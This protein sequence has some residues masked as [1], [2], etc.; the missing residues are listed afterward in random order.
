MVVDVHVET[1]VTAVS[2]L[3]FY[4]SAVVVAAMADSVSETA[5]AEMVADAISS[6]LSFFF[7]AAVAATASARLN[8]FRHRVCRPPGLQA[9]TVCLLTG[10]GISCKKPEIR[11]IPFSGFSI[12]L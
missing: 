8:P 11:L 7:A 10:S 6:G 12:L 2:G 1:A 3:S 9:I 4:F 5:V